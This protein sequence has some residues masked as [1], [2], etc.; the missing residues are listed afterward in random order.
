MADPT[1]NTS[2]PKNRTVVEHVHA[3]DKTTKVM[4]GLAVGAVA[5]GVLGA[6]LVPLKLKVMLPKLGLKTLIP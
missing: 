5:V 3:L 1:D 6:A 4:L 2:E